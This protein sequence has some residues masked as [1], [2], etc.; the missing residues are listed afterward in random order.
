MAILFCVPLS[1]I[2]KDLPLQTTSSKTSDLTKLSFKGELLAQELAKTTGIALNP[3]L[4][5]SALGAY[6]YY[7]NEESSRSSLPWHSLPTF[8]GPLAVIMGLILLKE[9]SKIAL[10]KVLTI[11]LDALEVLFEK[12]TSALIAIPVIFSSINSGEF[13]QMQM[14]SQHVSDFLF[15]VAMAGESSAAA[16]GSS[17]FM[18]T[19]I[20]SVVLFVLYV[21][22]WVLSQG[23]N[24]L[25]LLCPFSTIDLLLATGKNA[26]VVAILGFSNTYIGLILSL[27]VILIS[28]YL[29]PKA[30]RLVIFGTIISYDIILFR[31]F[32]KQTKEITAGHEVAAFTSCYF[33]DIAP[34]SYGTIRQNRGSIIFTHRPFYLLKK[35]S[36]N[37]GLH[38]TDCQ[39]ADTFLSP[40]FNRKSTNQK[41]ELQLFRIRPMYCA[42]YDDLAE[43]LGVTQEKETSITE[44][45]IDGFRWFLS[46]LTK[47]PRIETTSHEPESS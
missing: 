12:N 40:V 18:A 11:P 33:S 17:G 9:S 8:W 19:F 39:L 5:I 28:F 37:L 34:L 42:K 36:L 43:L 45:F 10:P 20:T 30:L 46:L 31:L 4:C 44:K 14:L 13:E 35:Q 7:S 21:V 38:N 25:M 3:L 1:S 47:S 32:N 16:I 27:F 22:V 26:L 6:N 23:F 29:F 2:A 41:Q 24:I 15:P